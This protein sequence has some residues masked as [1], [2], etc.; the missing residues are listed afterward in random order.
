LNPYI[1][2]HYRLEVANDVFN[3]TEYLSYHPAMLRTIHG[4]VL[5]YRVAWHYS[6]V[7]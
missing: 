6:G 2:W 7:L 1:V 3:G 4:M 5:Y